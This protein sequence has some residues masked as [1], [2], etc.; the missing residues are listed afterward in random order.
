MKT[1]STP[2]LAEYGTV[3]EMTHGTGGD[4]PDLVFENGQLVN[5]NTNCSDPSTN[6]TS[7]LIVD[8]S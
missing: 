8:G 6:T 4:K 3:I 2:M 5:T 1:Y 7:C